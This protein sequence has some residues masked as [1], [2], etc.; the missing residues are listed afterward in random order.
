MSLWDFW[1]G[2]LYSPVE[3][4]CESHCFILSMIHSISAIPKMSYKDEVKIA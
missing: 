4:A 2:L 1:L 3:K